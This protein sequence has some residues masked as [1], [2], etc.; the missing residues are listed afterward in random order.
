MQAH[1]GHDELWDKEEKKLS[2]TQD[3]D[4]SGRM[5][6]EG[7]MIEAEKELMTPHRVELRYEYVPIKLRYLPLSAVCTSQVRDEFDWFMRQ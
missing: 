2:L 3:G 1:H 7:E 5:H 4:V 6:V